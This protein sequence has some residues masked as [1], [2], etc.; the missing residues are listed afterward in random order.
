MIDKRYSIRSDA[1]ALVRQDGLLGVK[2]LE[3]NPGDPL[4]PALSKGQALGNPGKSP[5]SVD[6]LIQKF[7]SVADNV[8]EITSSLKDAVVGANHQGQLKDMV[9]RFHI[10]SEKIASF[11]EGLDRIVGKNENDVNA[12]V[13]DLRNFAHDLRAGYPTNTTP[14]LRKNYSSFGYGT[15]TLYGQRFQAV[16][17]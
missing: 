14:K 9:S 17:V 11:S 15:I 4:L 13:A 5:A 16:L 10:A 3:I 1:T 8:E 2:F 12:L 7:S 6:S